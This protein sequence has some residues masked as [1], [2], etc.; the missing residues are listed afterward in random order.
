[1]LISWLPLFL[2]FVLFTLVVAIHPENGPS[3]E[4]VIFLLVGFIPAVLLWFA[5]P[6]AHSP[7][8]V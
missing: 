5:R 1:M 7:N 6:R 3:S 4:W 8:E 2:A